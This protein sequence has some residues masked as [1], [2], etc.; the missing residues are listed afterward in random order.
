M[1]QY[2]GS[3]SSSGCW[4]DC[5]LPSWHRVRCRVTSRKQQHVDDLLYHGLPLSI[6]R[7]VCNVKLHTQL[8]LLHDFRHSPTN[9]RSDTSHL[10]NYFIP[11][12]DIRPSFCCA[13]PSPLAAKP[14]FNN[15]YSFIFFGATTLTPPTLRTLL[16]F[17]CFDVFFAFSPLPLLA[18]LIHIHYFSVVFLF[19]FFLVAALFLLRFLPFTFRVFSSSRWWERFFLICNLFNLHALNRNFD[20]SRRCRIAVGGATQ[21]TEHNRKPVRPG[22]DLATTSKAAPTER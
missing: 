4:G 1:G 13:L 14:R 11:Q 7:L 9:K 5:D 22:Q 20:S 10:L 21:K 2:D 18:T 19:C 3:S 17:S 8:P 15:I 16:L 12:S 6:C